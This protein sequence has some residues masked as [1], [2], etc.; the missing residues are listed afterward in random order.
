MASWRVWVGVWGNGRVKVTMRHGRCPCGFGRRATFGGV[1]RENIGPGQNRHS[2]LGTVPRDRYPGK[3]LKQPPT[4]QAAA[5]IVIQ[6]SLEPSTAKVVDSRLNRLI[7][8]SSDST[9]IPSKTRLGLPNTSIA[10][11]TF[12]SRECGG[13]PI[14]RLTCW[15]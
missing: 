13:L 2:H 8:K 7:S 6:R 5:F 12:A 10:S 15:L 4:Y 9:A 1:A 11:D 3:G 14:R